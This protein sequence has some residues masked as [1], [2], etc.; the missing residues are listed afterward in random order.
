MVVE[1]GDSSLRQSLSKVVC[2]ACL[3]GMQTVSSPICDA[4]GLVFKSRAGEDHLCETCIQAPSH[5]RKARSALAYTE[6]CSR[7]VQAFK[8]NGKIQLSR[9]LGAILRATF[10]RYWQA[11]DFDLIVPVPLHRRKLKQRGF[12]Q[13]WLMMR[14]WAIL[15]R[16]TQAPTAS[17]LFDGD[18]I[19]RTLPTHSQTGLGRQERIANLRNAFGLKGK[20][21]LTDLSV[22]LVDDVYTTGATANECARMLRKSGARQVDV[23]TL[24][25]AL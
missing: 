9:P 8:Y 17:T 22:L 4:C 19:V 10:N 25:R 16:D 18:V 15:D 6:P 7:L 1:I 21:T 11:A 3:E 24:A 2:R 23:L 12:N 5:F 14:Q 20:K 13:V